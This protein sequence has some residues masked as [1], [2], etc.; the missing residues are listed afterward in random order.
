MGLLKV[1]PPA[2]VT[3]CFLVLAMKA[4]GAPLTKTDGKIGE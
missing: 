2:L 1:S 4:R 3:G